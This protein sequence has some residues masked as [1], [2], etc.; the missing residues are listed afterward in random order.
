MKDCF[1]LSK[2]QVYR[3]KRDHY[4]VEFHSV[5]IQ[6]GEVTT[7]R[8]TRRFTNETLTTTLKYF[9]LDFENAV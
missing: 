7:I 2:G 9:I 5:N 4:L 6:W 8:L 3:H 1:T